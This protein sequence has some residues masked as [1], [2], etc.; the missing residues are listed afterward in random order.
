[1]FSWGTVR[2]WVCTGR[3]AKKQAFHG[4]DRA[5]VA[6]CRQCYDRWEHDGRK[7]GDCGNPVLTGHEVGAFLGRQ[8]LGHTQCGALRIAL[9]E[10]LVK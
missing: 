8:V 10:V 1:M 9:D 6:V 7:C 4:T 2:C 3:V 5:D